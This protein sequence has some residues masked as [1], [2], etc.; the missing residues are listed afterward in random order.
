MKENY[1]TIGNRIQN[2]TLNPDTNKPYPNID[3]NYGPYHSVDEALS[4]LPNTIR[5]VGLKFGVITDEGIVEYQFNN[6]LEPIEFGIKYIGENLI[7]INGKI[8]TIDN[9]VINYY[10]DNDQK[11][12]NITTDQLLWNGKAIGDKPMAIYD[13]Q[14]NKILYKIDNTGYLKIN[15]IGIIDNINKTRFTFRDVLT[16]ISS[17]END[18][19]EQSY[20]NL[21]NDNYKYNKTGIDFVG[22]E[23]RFNGKL[24]DPDNIKITELYNDSY[25]IIAFYDK[26]LYISYSDINDL[27]SGSVLQLT[28]NSYNFKPIKLSN[29]F[30]EQSASDEKASTTIITATNDKK[31]IIECIAND[32]DKEE[33]IKLQIDKIELKL[34]KYKLKK[35][36]EL[37]K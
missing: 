12:I 32:V 23:F 7:K 18:D 35:L 9:T 21:Y 22:D 26:I 2:N 8:I 30:I 25:K 29:T 34:D 31:I 14:G 16:Y 6:E 20:I 13:S 33:Y 36:E 15:S 11:I 24:F 4:A 1:I 28:N 37:L 10:K 27:K 19:N 3:K 17:P 5:C